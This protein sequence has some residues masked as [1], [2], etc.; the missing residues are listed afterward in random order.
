MAVLFFERVIP[1]LLLFARREN[2]T[3]FLFSFARRGSRS[4]VRSFVGDE[5]NGCRGNGFPRNTN[6]QNKKSF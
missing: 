6:G 2:E 3:L 4:F 1:D 5:A